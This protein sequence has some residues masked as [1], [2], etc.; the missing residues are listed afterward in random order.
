MMTSQDLLLFLEG[1]D[2][3][4]CVSPIHCTAQADSNKTSNA[5]IFYNTKGNIYK[6]NGVRLSSL[7][8][9]FHL[10]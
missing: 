5:Q 10:A 3:C 4:L 7:R 9:V 8:N 6:G 2:V 1:Y